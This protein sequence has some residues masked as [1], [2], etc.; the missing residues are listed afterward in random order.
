MRAVDAGFGIVAAEEIVA[1]TLDEIERAV[2]IL[3]GIDLHQLGSTARLSVSSR[4]DQIAKRVRGLRY[5][6]VD[7]VRREGD[8]EGS[9]ARTAEIF[10]QQTANGNC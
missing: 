7:A 2:D 3:A 5:D 4:M 6:V 1:V 10:E 8:W 9:G